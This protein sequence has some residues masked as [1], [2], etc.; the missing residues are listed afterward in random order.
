MLFLLSLVIW[1]AVSMLIAGIIGSI[2]SQREINNALADY[3]EADLLKT[4]EESAKILVGKIR[5]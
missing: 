1:L 4:W 5:E 3:V 2:R